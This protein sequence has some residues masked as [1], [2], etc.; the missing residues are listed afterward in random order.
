MLGSWS[1]IGRALLEHA[2][3]FLYLRGIASVRL[4]AT[5]LGRPLYEKLGFAAECELARFAGRPH[6]SLFPYPQTEPATADDIE[7]I[8]ALDHQA[9][10]TDRARLLQY[11][12]TQER[13]DAR[14]IRSSAGIDACLL[15]RPGGLAGRSAP[16]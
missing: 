4:D 2:L 5:P 11:V 15:D 12:L 10:G 13:A 7:S 9:T 16:A 8:V 1:G 3:A 14:V 6:G